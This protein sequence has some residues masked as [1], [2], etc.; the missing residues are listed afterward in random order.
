LQ[1]LDPDNRRFNPRLGAFEQ[2]T[3]AT[4]VHAGS[5]EVL[6]NSPR[7]LYFPQFASGD[8]CDAFRDFGEARM[9]LSKKD[10]IRNRFVAHLPHER[11]LENATL[12]RVLHRIARQTKHPV[13]TFQVGGFVGGSAAAAR[14]TAG[15]SVGAGGV[16]GTAEL[17]VLVL[18]VAQT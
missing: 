3:S 2:I 9:T 8:E 14:G 4:E 18:V 16:T 11:M 10:L 17:L 1:P 6:S 12:A 5:F 13:E 7:I 15:A